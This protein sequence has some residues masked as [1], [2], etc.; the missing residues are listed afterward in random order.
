MTIEG[1][2]LRAAP[3]GAVLVLLTTACGAGEP[4]AGGG[5]EPSPSA[6]A[7]EPV[8]GDESG[9][10]VFDQEERKFLAVLD[11]V[12]GTER[13]RIL[14]PEDN[15]MFPDPE[16]PTTFSADYSHYYRFLSEEIEIF[17]LEGEKDEARLVRTISPQESTL[18]GGNPEIEDDLHYDVET[19]LLWYAER[20]MDTRTVYTVDIE[21]EEE[22]EKVGQ[23]DDPNASWVP[24]PNGPA[25]AE[26][27]YTGEG[28]SEHP[29]IRY[30]EVD[31]ERKVNA[32]VFPR[33]YPISRGMGV[34][35]IELYDT[36]LLRKGENQYLVANNRTGMLPEGPAAGEI[37]EVTV[38]PDLEIE[39]WRTIVP[40]RESPVG[41]FCLSPDGKSLVV[42]ASG[43]WYTLPLDDPENSVKVPKEESG[44]WLVGWI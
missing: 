4:S 6:S 18:A 44:P 16:A 26:I 39:E 37:I 20:N 17:R 7:T 40:E 5:G 32:V 9:L 14:L 42:E 24:G 23:F 15:A 19:G 30:Q 36:G 22:P 21:G 27:G 10:V 29:V 3:I 35:D 13:D 34:R 25:E 8:W 12:D 41:F 11:P 33:E 43:E 2:V 38:S 28:P 31:G 1:R